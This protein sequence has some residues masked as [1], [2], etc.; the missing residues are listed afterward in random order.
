MCPKVSDGPGAD[1]PCSTRSKEW[2]KEVIGQLRRLR[3]GCGCGADLRQADV[4]GR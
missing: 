2:A 1:V 3:Y 4:M